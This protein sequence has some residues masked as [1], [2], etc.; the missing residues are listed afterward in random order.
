MSRQTEGKLMKVVHTYLSITRERVFAFKSRSNVDAYKIQQLYGQS[1][2]SDG[3]LSLMAPLLSKRPTPWLLSIICVNLVVVRFGVNYAW[4][5]GVATL[6]PQNIAAARHS[7]QVGASDVNWILVLFLLSIL[8][9]EQCILSPS[10]I[11]SVVPPLPWILRAYSRA[12]R[13][14]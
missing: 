7:A 5:D 2:R 13:E 3:N 6:I 4:E 10:E 14:I 1:A 8:E 12:T 11:R 9:E